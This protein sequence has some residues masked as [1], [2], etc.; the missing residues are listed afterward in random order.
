[1]GKIV[2]YIKSVIVQIVYG[3]RYGHHQQSFP[4]FTWL[5][6]LA[7]VAGDSCQDEDDAADGHPS[8]AIVAGM[9]RGGRGGGRGVGRGGRGGGCG[10]K[11]R[12]KSRGRARGC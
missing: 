2:G 10:A 4:C 8:L 1:M 6:N 3:D 9:G 5:P 7:I 12:A 11:G